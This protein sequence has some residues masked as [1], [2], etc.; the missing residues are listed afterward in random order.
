M[1]TPRVSKA[2]LAAYPDAPAYFIRALGFIDTPELIKGQLNP[3][4]E[5]WLVNHTRFPPE[6]INAKTAWC[7]AF[8]SA[9]LEQ[10]GYKSPHSAAAAKYMDIGKACPIDTL[11]SVL[12][13]RRGTTQFHVAF[14][15]GFAGDQV[16]LLG[17]NQSNKVCIKLDSQSK[18]LSA[19][20]PARS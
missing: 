10:S 14:N 17:G 2:L 7:G 19:R 8:V 3:L 18:I 5:A 12:V 20:L 9:M 11:Y 13:L 16:M 4:V 1:S 6:Q 15:A